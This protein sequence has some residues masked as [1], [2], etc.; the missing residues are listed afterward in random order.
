MA[1]KIIAVWDLGATKCAV[2]LVEFDSVTE[3]FCC[4]RDTTLYLNEFFSLEDLTEG[5]E[6]N[7]G[8]GFSEVDRILIAGAGIYDGQTLNLANGFPYPM[9]FACLAASCAWPEMTVVHDY[10][11]IIC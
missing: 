6:S 1:K 2:G 9:T 10:V 7:L 4:L 8:I 5:L 3:S 11:P